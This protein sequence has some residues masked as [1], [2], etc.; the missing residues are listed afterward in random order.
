M[1]PHASH[2][3]LGSCRVTCCHHPRE[4][5]SQW[6]IPHTMIRCLV[7]SPLVCLC[8]GLDETAESV[9]LRVG[10][11]TTA[12]HPPGA[13]KSD[14]GSPAFGRAWRGSTISTAVQNFKVNDAARHNVVASNLRG[15]GVGRVLGRL[16]SCDTTC[17]KP[18]PLRQEPRA[19]AAGQIAI[20]AV[21][22]SPPWSMNQWLAQVNDW[23]Y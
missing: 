5:S 23:R 17:E 12:G 22:S 6:L 1:E 16:F 15:S 7:S 3:C 9:S 13:V 2:A 18:E 21:V 8:L 4:S 10:Q 19:I 14:V 11:V 20:V